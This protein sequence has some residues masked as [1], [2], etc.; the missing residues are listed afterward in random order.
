MSDQ[1]ILVAGASG[2]LGRIVLQQILA[3]GVRHIVAASRSPEKLKEFASPD[4][5]L[6]FADFNEPESLPKAFEGASAMLLISTDDL[7]SGKRLQQHKNAISAAAKAG[8]QHIVYTSMPAP[9]ASTAIFF[10]PDHA[11]TEAALRESGL[12]HSILR[13]AWY[14]E[15][16]LDIGFIAATLRAGTWFTSAGNGRIA[17]IPCHDVGRAV[18]AA[19]TRH[20][21]ASATYDITGPAALTPEELAEALAEASGKTINV[22]HVDDQKLI[23]QLVAIGMP[24]Q[25]ASMVLTTDANVRDG[26]FDIVSGAVQELTGKPPSTFGNFLRRNRERMLR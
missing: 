21:D 11:A 22:V 18:A 8:V 10:S 3:S 19:L 4:V 1:R 24:E 23:Q 13:I 16:L 9:E 17:Y 26:H 25:L 20:A 7:L 12:T 2:R 5:E 6:R 14:A 15:N